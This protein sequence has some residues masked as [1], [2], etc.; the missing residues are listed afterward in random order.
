MEAGMSL[1]RFRNAYEER[2]ALEA[3]AGTVLRLPHMVRVWRRPADLAGRVA[4]WARFAAWLLTWGKA[5][6][7]PWVW[8]QQP[9]I[10][11]IPPTG[12]ADGVIRF[13]NCVAYSN[14]GFHTLIT[15]YER[16]CSDLTGGR[17]ASDMVEHARIA[18]RAANGFPPPA[19]TLPDPGRPI[20]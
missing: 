19:P 14:V 8:E 6:A 9:S 18:E 3:A 7:L 4:L 17:R 15:F 12:S 20:R 2:Q 1:T 11:L 10:H 5:G 16:Q 13:E